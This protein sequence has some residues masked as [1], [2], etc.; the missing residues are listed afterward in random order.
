MSKLIGKVLDG[1][2]RLT[3][4]IG[5]GGM[6]SVYEAEHEVISRRVAVKMLNPEYADESDVAERF[7]REAKA[8]SAIGHPN[9]IDIQDVGEHEGATYIVME[10]LEGTSLS[11]LI[12]SKGRL[13]PAH[14]VSIARQVADGLEAA[15]SKGIVHRDL[16]ADNVFLTYDP[17]LGEQVKILDFGISKVM[18]KD[19]TDLT[20]TGAVMGTPHYMA[21]EQ[22]RGEKDVDARIDVWALGVMIYQMLTGMFPFPGSKTPEVLVR[23]LTEPMAGLEL[24]DLPDEMMEVVERALEKDRK[25]RFQ[26]VA[27]LRKALEPLEG[28]SP[29]MPPDAVKMGLDETV[30]T[31]SAQRRETTQPAKVPLWKHI[32]WYVIAI[33][34]AWAGFG[35]PAQARNMQENWG[36]PEHWPLWGVIGTQVVIALAVTGGV[37]LIHRFW[38]GGRWNRWLQGPLFVVFPSVGLLLVLYHYLTLRGQMASHLISLHSYT[39]ITE[40]HAGRISDL[41]GASCANF[42][43]AM[44]VDF[45]FVCQLSILILIA[46]LFIRRSKPEPGGRPRWL[47]LPAALVVIVIVEIAFAETLGFMGPVRFVMYLLWFLTA[48][49]LLRMGRTRIGGIQPGWHVLASGVISF[50]ALSG[51][52]VVMGYITANMVMASKSLEEMSASTREWIFST[53]INPN[54]VKGVIILWVVVLAL[55]AALGLVC[56]RSLPLKDLKRMAPSLATV[57]VTAA[58]TVILLVA[59]QSTSEQ[60][61]GYKFSRMQPVT[62]FTHPY[63]IDSG[64]EALLHGADGLYNA[65]THRSRRDYDEEELVEALAGSSKCKD[66]VKAEP[67]TCVTAIEAMLYCESYGKRLPTPE[68][69]DHALEQE[70]VERAEIGEWTMRVVHGTATF[71][72]KGADTKL[73]PPEFSP[74]VGFRCAYSFD[75]PG[76]S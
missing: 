76:G 56:R 63:Y 72:V 60:W 17:R 51:M 26:S 43:G 55:F 40:E 10:L 69:W 24:P 19:G 47:V 48:I 13:E 64:P 7:V 45:G 15:H 50:A 16:K 22:V 67:A 59:M 25:T 42:L 30:A 73:D 9:I 37:I 38:S 32:L 8:A 65:L 34:I 41:I 68:E 44:N 2:Y 14:V 31:P 61:S 74:D 58:P 35:P 4:L 53:E 29:E 27:E 36:L 3:K 52:H 57:A 1:K 5:K 62:S 70:D 33:P 46:F 54:M 75:S 21:P 11:S 39:Q 6:G 71:E 23:I 12:K 66:I 18:E 28:S 20:Q 49:A